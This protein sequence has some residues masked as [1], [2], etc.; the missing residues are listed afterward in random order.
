M[1]GPP[2]SLPLQIVPP[3]DE[4]RLDERHLCA[5]LVYANCDYIA[6]RLLWLSG[7]TE[8][9]LFHVQ[10]AVEKYLKAFLIARG[11]DFPKRT[12]NLGDLCGRCAEVDSWFAEERWS[13]WCE[14][15][16]YFSEVTRY[17]Q[18]KL[19]GWALSSKNLAYLDEFVYTVRER[20]PF[21]ARCLDDLGDLSR[22]D[23]RMM[24]G[25]GRIHWNIGFL[26]AL[27][28]GNKYFRRQGRLVGSESEE[29]T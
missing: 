16:T 21:P 20:M 22:G 9:A 19:G 3:T 23:G 17:P 24:D 11:R 8:V 25:L 15:L 10:Q 2:D 27:F 18:I 6:A 5:M 4:Q 29:A 1:G 12:H 7:L 13:K 14:R 26:D 28:R